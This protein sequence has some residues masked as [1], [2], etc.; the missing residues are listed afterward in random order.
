[1]SSHS[2]TT[3]DHDIIRQWVESRQGRPTRVRGTGDEH[4]EGIL[5]IDFAEPDEKLEEIS[6]EEFFE[7]F[8]DRKLAFLHQDQTAD[9]KTSRFFKFVRREDEGGSSQKGGS[10]AGRHAASPGDPQ[11]DPHA[12]R[13]GGSHPEGK[14]SD[15]ASAAHHASSNA[16]HKGSH[17]ASGG[18]RKDTSHKAESHQDREGGQ[19]H[20]SS[21]KDPRT[22]APASRRGG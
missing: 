15:H 21:H 12:G 11:G 10:G 22:G 18:S 9:G 5:R 6:W 7:T 20:A 4:G 8:D 2:D 16:S 17:N 13:K 14:G 3:T 1:M 19:H